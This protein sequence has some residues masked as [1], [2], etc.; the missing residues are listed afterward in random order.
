[1]QNLRQ[2]KAILM[3][4]SFLTGIQKSPC[5]M[6]KLE[7]Y[8][9]QP[10]CVSSQSF[11]GM[12]ITDNFVSRYLGTCFQW[13]ITRSKLV[14]SRFLF[15]EHGGTNPWAVGQHMRPLLRMSCT[16]SAM[17]LYL[18]ALAGRSLHPTC[19]LLLISLWCCARMVHPEALVKMKLKSPST[20][21]TLES[22]YCAKAPCSLSSAGTSNHLSML[23]TTRFSGKDCLGDCRTAIPLLPT[24]Q[25]NSFPF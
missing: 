10:S 17:I 15:S 8:W 25:L 19:R 1:M 24:I 16:Q 18:L 9:A 3:M 4:S 13:S 22:T 23:A 14:P 6:S 11:Q 21:L 12:G 5:K 7:N 2:V 20:F